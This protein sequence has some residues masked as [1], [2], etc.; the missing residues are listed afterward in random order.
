[1]SDDLTKKRPLDATRINIHQEYEVN[2]WC[3]H[4]KVTK[5][6]LVAAVKA[7]GTSAAVVQKHLGK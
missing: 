1:M 3:D 2:W 5:A 6:Q 4:F 7:V